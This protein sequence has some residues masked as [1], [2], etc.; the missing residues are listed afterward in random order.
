MARARKDIG[1]LLVSDRIKGWL[2]A[3]T[4]QSSNNTILIKQA[5]GGCFT[6]SSTGVRRE[7]EAQPVG[8]RGAL[9]GVPFAV[10]D[11][12]DALPHPTTAACDA[13]QYT[14]AHSASTV[15]ALENEGKQL[16]P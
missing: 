11:N 3:Q 12:I 13:F 15:A 16:V 1:T 4:C 7:L 5:S 6:H 2:I 8:E 10:K 14:P 9:W